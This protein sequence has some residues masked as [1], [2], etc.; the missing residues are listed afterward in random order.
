MQKILFPLVTIILNY[1]ILFTLLRNSNYQPLD[2]VSD[3]KIEECFATTSP[4]TGR[5]GNSLFAVATA[6]LRRN[7]K[8]KKKPAKTAKPIDLKG[9]SAT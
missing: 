5:G 6:Y 2:W 8:P 3:L 9:F 1:C 4:Q 7:K